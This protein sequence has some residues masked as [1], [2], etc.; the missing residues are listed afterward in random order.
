MNADRLLEM[1]PLLVFAEILVLDPFEAVARDLPAGL[2]HGFRLLGRT[3]KRGRD[4]IDSERNI[5]GREQ[6]PEPPEAGSG[7]VF[8][9]RLHV[10]VALTGPR[11]GAD[12]LRKEG[13]RRG[14][15]MEDVVLAAF[16]VIEHELHRDRGA[17][18]PSR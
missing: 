3:L 11:L 2:L 14:V 10:P 9:D 5:A 13:F 12:D 4:A 7:A 17:S 1:S 6:A 18:R 16:L 8:V 15:A